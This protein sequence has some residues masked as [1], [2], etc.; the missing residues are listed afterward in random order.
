MRFKEPL[1]RSNLGKVKV[2]DIWMSAL[3]AKCH[4]C[5]RTPFDGR[6]RTGRSALIT[7]ASAANC[8]LTV[9]SDGLMT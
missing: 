8:E 4:R 2:A 5:Q 3:A 6:D 1:V 9:V 7:P